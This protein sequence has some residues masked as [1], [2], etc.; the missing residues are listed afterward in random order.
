VD[1]QNQLELVGAAAGQQ[2]GQSVAEA[3]HAALEDSIAAHFPGNALINCMCHN[4]SVSDCIRWL[5]SQVCPRQLTAAADSFQTLGELPIACVHGHCKAIDL[6][7][8]QQ[9]H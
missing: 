5:E 9:M 7:R 2:G 3:W 6:H 8:M 1:V 4:T